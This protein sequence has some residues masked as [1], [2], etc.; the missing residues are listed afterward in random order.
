[1]RLKETPN[2]FTQKVVGSTGSRSVICPATPSSKPAAFSL[3][4][5][6]SRRVDW[7]LTIFAKDPESGRQAS[8]KILSF[9]VFVVED[10][11]T[12]E[13]GHLHAGL[14]LAQARLQRSSG[15]RLI[16]V[17]RRFCSRWWRHLGIMSIRA[18]QPK[19]KILQWKI[20]CVDEKEIY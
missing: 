12:G 17:G 16:T 18:V 3:K 2:G 10:E 1:M 8:F 20:R 5:R 14:S 19:K 11:W 4:D 15:R 13:L 7:V 9:F 6:I